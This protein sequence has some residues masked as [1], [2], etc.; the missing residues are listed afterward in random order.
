[1]Q[2]NPRSLL[3]DLGN[4]HPRLPL[5]SLSVR[6][7]ILRVLQ[8]DKPFPTGQWRGAR[9]LR[10]VGLN[11]HSPPAEHVLQHHI[12][13]GAPAA[14]GGR[15]RRRCGGG[16]ALLVVLEPGCLGKRENNVVRAAHDAFHAEFVGEATEEL[17]VPMQKAWRAA[18]RHAREDVHPHCRAEDEVAA[19]VQSKQCKV[20]G[21]A[22]I[23]DRRLDP[24]ACRVQELVPG[25]APTG[26]EESGD[27]MQARHC[28][29][30]V[31][32]PLFE[33]LRLYEELAGL[34]VQL[35]VELLGRRGWGWEKACA[36]RGHR[37][38]LGL[39]VQD[40]EKGDGRFHSGVLL[41]E[42]GYDRAKSSLVCKT[43]LDAEDL[44][45]VAINV[46]FGLEATA[47]GD[48]HWHSV[49]SRVL[50]RQ[51]DLLVRRRIRVG[52]GRVVRNNGH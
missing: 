23:A 17:L 16:L 6:R 22:M 12:R 4:L 13:L 19:L 43:I 2:V 24:V 28:I 42:R 49:R 11:L 8:L 7:S 41:R 25:A 21:L 9:D 1:M 32:P 3:E 51:Y 14:I 20:W 5:D 48:E 33:H 47:R 29:A 30:F 18:E 15:S 38:R 46:E 27:E 40:G 37:M 26:E 39:N 50:I 34:F 35:V 31:Q 36:S 52:R 44:I 45:E 10:D